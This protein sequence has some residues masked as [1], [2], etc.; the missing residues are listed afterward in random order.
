M[1]TARHTL[2]RLIEL[3][4]IGEDHIREL[5][6]ED[7]ECA[8]V[9][10][11]VRRG[12]LTQYQA[13]RVLANDTDG[14]VLGNYA[15]LDT[16]GAGG[17]GQ[18]FLAEH[19]RMGRRVALKMLPDESA[20]DADAIAR[21]RREVRAAA[22]L[23]HPNIVTAH[24]ADEANGRHFLVMEY[25]AGRDLSSH[26]ATHG[27]MTV[28]LAVDCIRQAARGLEYAHQRGIVHRDV[29]PSNLL[30]DASGTIKILDLGLA[31]FDDTLVDVEDQLTATGMVMGTF[32]FMSPEQAFDTRTADASSDVYSLGC[33]LYFLLHG[34]PMFRGMTSV[35]KILAHRDAPPPSL[36]EGRD[37]VPEFVDEVYRRMVAKHPNDRFG[38]MA[39]VD[40]ALGTTST[41]RSE[42]ITPSLDRAPGVARTVSIDLVGSESSDPVGIIL[43]HYGS[44]GRFEIRRFIGQGVFAWVYEAFDQ[45]LRDRAAIRIG[46][47]W[48]TDQFD[49]NL[50][51]DARLARELARDCDHVVGVFDVGVDESGQSWIAMEYLEGRTLCE[52][53][54]TANGP[55]AASPLRALVDQV[56]EAL[57]R[58]HQIGLAHRNL[59]PRNVMECGEAGSEHFKIL[60][61]GLAGRIHAD[62]LTT[63]QRDGTGALEYVSPE[64]SVASPD[65]EIDHR[66]DIYGF[67][68]LLFEALTNRVP[69]RLPQK[70]SSGVQTLLTAIKSD[71]PPPFP[72]PPE[73]FTS[74]Q[75]GLL[76]KLVRQ[77]LDKQP[78][79]RP[80]T[81]REVRERFLSILDRPESP[82]AIRLRSRAAVVSAVAVVALGI[83]AYAVVPAII[84]SPRPTVKLES[85]TDTVEL[86]PATTSRFSVHLVNGL[87]EGFVCELRSD[88]LPERT[89]A[90][91][92][93][94]GPPD[95]ITVECSADVVGPGTREGELTIVARSRTADEFEIATTVAVRVAAP[96]VLLPEAATPHGDEIVDTKEGLFYKEIDVRAPSPPSEHDNWQMRFLLVTADDAEFGGAR[97][98]YYIM[99]DKVSVDQFL[100]FLRN[101]RPDEF[102]DRRSTCFGQLETEAQV[103][104]CQFQPES[105][106]SL[107]AFN[108]SIG[109]AVEYCELLT[110]T[111]GDGFRARVPS[112]VEWD[113]AF[114]LYRMKR[115][116]SLQQ[117]PENW[118]DDGPFGEKDEVA[119]GRCLPRPVNFP[120]ADRTAYGCRNMG[121]NGVEWTRDVALQAMT[122]DD[123]KHVRDE[124]VPIC[125]RGRPHSHAGEPW[126]WRDLV[127]E[128]GMVRDCEDQE[129]GCIDCESTPPR[130]IG[131][132]VVLEINPDG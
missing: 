9:A 5:D 119:I 126:G 112:T 84:P 103:N 91:I 109:E 74:S 123:P 92:V 26:V 13:D 51:R 68:V 11:L 49:D 73:E 117:V 87:R 131:F 2:D 96:N 81:I 77:C 31:R 108:V 4:L 52:I 33:T 83:T 38:T 98:P 6:R 8:A 130:F 35:Q 34:K 32:D 102:A 16:L 129:P 116:S 90:T 39:D 75:W 37:D 56:G 21:F 122:I 45:H 55:L 105:F 58:A 14:L 127:D 60:D 63:L 25:V 7:D 128:Q 113:T 22:H 50:L 10:A 115:R 70:D 19:L 110:E 88:A 59:S 53:F 48:N 12:V 24:D 69:F 43:S 41:E 67:G 20:A 36:R 62:Q 97:R 106:G 94:A 71:L 78:R 28:D 66:T 93:D 64:Q 111:L 125:V 29:K 118:A 95:W 79:N 89:T 120:L 85:P 132:R 99:R 1:G 76:E 54:R 40:A 72:P 42:R 100:E 65:V 30:R 86:A 107:P 101:R 15:I 121:G 46:K 82:R 114:G 61:F 44:D 124:L 80:S 27:T 57:E 18:V 23:V 17:M 47:S 104:G 3:S